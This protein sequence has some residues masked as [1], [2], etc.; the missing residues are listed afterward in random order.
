M[1]RHEYLRT[2]ESTAESVPC[3][4]D[5]ALR[6]RVHDLWSYYADKQMYGGWSLKKCLENCE[7]QANG[8]RNP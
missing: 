6:R 3:E 5:N 8:R 1:D 2:I 7:A 4:D